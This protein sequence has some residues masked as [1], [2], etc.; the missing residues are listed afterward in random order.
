M[1]FFNNLFGVKFPDY[2]S[3]CE[4]FD[5]LR[6]NALDIIDNSTTAYS[7][8][9]TNFI[10]SQPDNEISLTTIQENG[11]TQIRSMR[12]LFNTAS[13]L[14]SELQILKTLHSRINEIQNE[15]QSAQN[16]EKKARNDDNIA[17]LNLEK[18]KGRGQPTEISR[19]EQKAALSNSKLSQAI[20]NVEEKKK[21][22]DRSRFEYSKDFVGILLRTLQKS[23]NEKINELNELI[24]ISQE[25]IS[26]ASQIQEYKDP[27]TEILQKKLLELDS[28]TI[29]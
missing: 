12:H 10:K 18:A 29:D 19:M 25:I 27:A 15:F 24:P 20:K 6:L 1:N 17:Q 26:A 9:F 22:Y 13:S 23:T 2:E 7:Q 11:K 16:N 3:F 21:S 28:V 8:R 4:T 14:P 5:E